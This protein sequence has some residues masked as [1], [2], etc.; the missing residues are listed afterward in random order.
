MDSFETWLESS[1]DARGGQNNELVGPGA[2]EARNIAGSASGKFGAVL[3]RARRE[4]A[5]LLGKDEH[6]G[7]IE[8]SRKRRIPNLRCIDS[9]KPRESSGAEQGCGGRAL[10]ASLIP[11]GARSRSP[12]NGMKYT[13]GHLSLFS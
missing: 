7:E 5:G 4:K 1:T 8:G 3:L 12:L 2:D 13:L 9:K 6:A 11:G 10:W